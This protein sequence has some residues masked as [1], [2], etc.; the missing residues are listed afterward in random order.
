[1]RY[2]KARM[3]VWKEVVMNSCMSMCVIAKWW[4]KAIFGGGKDQ[5]CILSKFWLLQLFELKT[6]T[7]RFQL[8]NFKHLLQV[9]FMNDFI[10]LMNYNMVLQGPY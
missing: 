9:W 1:M 4:V 6:P 5:W 3:I 10:D 7:Y 8:R 2:M